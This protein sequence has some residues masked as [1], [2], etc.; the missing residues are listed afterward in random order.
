MSSSYSEDLKFC[1]DVL[2]K[3]KFVCDNAK[4]GN[5]VE[6]FIEAWNHSSV[7]SSSLLERTKMLCSLSMSMTFKI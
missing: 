5:G 2:N 1:D 4:N 6:F 7:S 3:A